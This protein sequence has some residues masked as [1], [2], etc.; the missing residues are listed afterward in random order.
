MI[1]SVCF[2]VAGGS[3]QARWVERVGESGELYVHVDAY[4]R[5]RW[6]VGEIRYSAT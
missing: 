1:G 2:A 6:A 5:R 3:Q 4:R